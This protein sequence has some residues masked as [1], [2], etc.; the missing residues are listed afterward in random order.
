MFPRANGSRIFLLGGMACLVL[1]L[2]QFG[3]TRSYYRQQADQEVMEVVAEKSFDERWALPCF[4]IEMDPSSRIYDPYDPDRPPMPP[5][6]PDSHQFMHNIDG[7]KGYKK[8]H[9]NGSIELLEN[10]FWRG[11]LGEHVQIT[12]D[13]K[14]KLNLEDAVR[15][16]IMHSSRY[17]EQRETLYLSALDVSTERFRFDVQFFGGAD[18]TFLHLGSET[19]FGESNTLTL[20]RTSRSRTQ[21]LEFRKRFATAGELLVGFA[22][23]FVWEFSGGD[24]NVTSS[25]LNFS[26]VQ[27]LLRA[28]GRAIALEQLTIAERS[29]LANLRAYQH[30][31]QGFF[32]QMAVG[33][34]GNVQG[35]RR[36]GGFFGGTG[37]TGFTGQG[38]GGFGGVGQATG[39]G[40]GGFGFDAG[41]GGGGGGALGAG[42][43]AGTVGG[44]IGLLQ[45]QQ[46]LS[47]RE[48]NLFLQAYIMT[49]LE[50]SQQAGLIDVSQ[51]LQFQQSI[52]TEQ[53]NLL[54]ARNSL[55]DS[56]DSFKAFN[57]GLPPDLQLELDDSLIRQFRFIDPRISSLQ[58]EILSFLIEFGEIEEL[59][60][61]D[62]KQALQRIIR[63]RNR[64]PELIEIVQGDL[65]RLDEAAS[66]RQ[67]EMNEKDRQE[68]LKRKQKYQN[69]LQRA[70]TEFSGTAETLQELKSG[71]SP[72]SKDKSANSLVAFAK[73]ISDIV[74]ELSLIQ[75]RTRVVA[76]QQIDRIPLT[77][78]DALNIAR[79]NRLDW[80]NNRAA[81]VDSWRLIEFNA[82][83]L[84]SDLDIFFEGDMGN[85][86]NGNPVK[87][88]G[89]DGTLR[90]GLRFDTPLTRLIERNN[91]RQQLI[92]Y[93]QA[94]RQLI[95]FEDGVSRSMRSRLR[96]LE[97]LRQNLEIQRRAVLISVDRVDQ[98][99]EMLVKPGQAFGPTLTRDMVDAL[100]SLRDAQNNF[101]S[102]WLNHSAARME[103]MRD[104]GLMRLDEKEMWVDIPL[105]EAIRTYSRECPLPPEV[106]EEWLRCAPCAIQAGHP[107][108]DNH[109]EP[110]T[111]SGK[112][113]FLESDD[114]R[115]REPVLD[116]S[117]ESLFLFD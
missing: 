45:Q 54:Q 62:L 55:E 117:S 68:F 95:G 88:R 26:I 61:Q 13:G 93:Q 89:Q 30:W 8:W 1:I 16:S 29:L 114:R 105:D 91:F 77:P 103:L 59:S 78:E 6:D 42:G 86:N 64:V 25:L 52:E 79:C 27:P 98:S 112:A 67:R 109:S 106:P 84:E 31:R 111:S 99:R 76:F 23:E 20:G 17:Q 48:E 44:F 63:F 83:A 66:A 74:G 101:M 51:V 104:L 70:K 107:L 35:P 3:C 12:P 11:C 102:V 32:T 82:N 47:N 115:D 4:N 19:P 57:L 110:I 9:D 53:A 18:T 15:L 39:F 34:N 2:P 38:S 46:Q 28:G 24:F 71:I 87:F 43:G 14:I 97:Q 10:P 108:Q 41:G 5:D 65:Q 37:L 58:N 92:N 75:A 60:L 40:R 73:G 56:L 69:D 7:K 94:R 81:L 100:E 21:T 113:D 90:A 22:N 116:L 80:M 85:L 36:R 49:L 50:N 33:S 96:V 72:D